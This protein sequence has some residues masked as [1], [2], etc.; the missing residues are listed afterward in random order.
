MSGKLHYKRI[1][2][3]LS[4]EALM[5]DQDFGISPDML[6]FVAKEVKS[7][8]DEGVE[9][10]LVIGGGNIFRGVGLA[11]AGMNRVYGD[12]MGMLATIIN[13]IAMQG[14]LED[15][16]MDVHVMSALSIDQVCEDYVRRNAVNHLAKGKITILTAGTGNPYFTTD[17]AASLRG[18]EIEADVVIK[19]TNVD[20]VYNS[21]PRKNP[22]AKMFKTLSYD[23]VISEKLNV[24]DATAIILCRDQKMPLRVYNMNTPGMLKSIVIDGS[25][26][27]TLVQ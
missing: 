12:H 3:K 22:D 18:L 13:S 2:L 20:G 26:D 7:I 17:S 4:G 23:K 16:G 10:A 1:L 6:S 21:D 25:D 5:G 14:A 8:H 27:G 11:S 24:M 15:A 9:I 19:A